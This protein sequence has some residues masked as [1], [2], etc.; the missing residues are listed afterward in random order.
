MTKN[1]KSRVHNLYLSLTYTSVNQ[2]LIVSKKVKK[3]NKQSI[4]LII[5]LYFRQLILRKTMSLQYI[6]IVSQFYLKII[7]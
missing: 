5:I 4:R 7:L 6:Y 1:G 2:S 3:I